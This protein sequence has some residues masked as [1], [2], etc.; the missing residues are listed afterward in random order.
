MVKDS[1]NKLDNKLHSKIDFFFIIDKYK[2]N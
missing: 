2:K 1:I